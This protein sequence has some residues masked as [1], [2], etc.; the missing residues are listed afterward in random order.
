MAKYTVIS[1]NRKSDGRMKTDY[2]QVYENPSL[3]NLRME[4]VDDWWVHKNSPLRNGSDESTIEIYSGTGSKI[5]YLGKLI[6]MSYIGGAL[7]K[8]A[9]GGSVPLDYSG[10]VV[11]GKRK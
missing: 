3:P 9:E 6:L 11:R 2:V 1:T 7:W 4:L 10:K 5:R 8:P